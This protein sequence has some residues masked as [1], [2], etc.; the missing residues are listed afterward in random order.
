VEAIPE[1]QGIALLFFK[2]KSAGVT[3]RFVPQDLFAS[4]PGLRS[5][6]TVQSG[7]TGLADPHTILLGAALAETLGVTSG[8]RLL[9]LTPYG[10]DGSGPPRIT[11][12]VVG[13]VFQT[14]YQELEKLYV[15][16]PLAASWFMLSP[17]AS[18]TMI[19]VRVKDPF[20]D[21][22]GA[23]AQIRSKL[24]DT[25]RI[26]SWR[27]LEYAR[28]QSFQTTKAL[29]LFIMALIVLVAG[30]NV[31]S[32]VI[33][34]AFERRMEIGILKS[35]GAGPSSLSFAFILSGFVTGLLGTVVGVALGLLA[36]VN[37]NQIIQ[38][39]QWVVNGVLA[40]YAAVKATLSSG[41]GS[42]EPVTIFN[43]AYYLSSIPI[44]I[45]WAEIFW[46]AAGTLALSGLASYFPA[47][48]AARAR[49]LEVIRKV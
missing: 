3:L 30:V 19:G 16:A 45:H 22:S 1:R 36:A 39:L 31:S 32:S 21:L 25:A 15:F 6:V 12:V 47:A 18:S 27:E 43:S 5:L 9:A 7:S 41:A 40:A 34:I 46:A 2:G 4:D 11:P 35:V 28:L 10:E 20:A 44:R 33:M 14:G 29:L 17:R 38:A 48:R 37:I 49:P 26:Y 13:G 24:P 42:V 23:M 8:D